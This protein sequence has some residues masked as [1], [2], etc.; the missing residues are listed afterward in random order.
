MAVI[1]PVLIPWTIVVDTAALERWMDT[2]GIDL[3]DG[4]PTLF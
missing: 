3:A 1:E 4:E 2:Q